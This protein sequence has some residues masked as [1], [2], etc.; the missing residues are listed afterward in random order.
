LKASSLPVTTGT[1]VA[2]EPEQRPQT[3]MIG[4]ETPLVAELRLQ[5]LR[6]GQPARMN[7]TPARR[8]R[9]HFNAAAV[10]SFTARP[11]LL[12]ATIDEAEI[13]YEQAE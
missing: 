11:F 7:T 1:I 12:T 2:M 8:T 10:Q 4:I 5:I 13:D 6:H 3:L 9:I